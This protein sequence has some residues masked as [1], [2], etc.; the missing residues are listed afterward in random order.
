[1]NSRGNQWKYGD[2]YA[3]ALHAELESEPV[4]WGVVGFEPGLA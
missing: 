3:W 1:V 2:V 4:A